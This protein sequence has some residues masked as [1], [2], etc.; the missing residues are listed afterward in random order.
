MSTDT[1]NERPRRR[2]ISFFS[3]FIFIWLSFVSVVVAAGV[4]RLDVM[5]GKMKDGATDA[6]LKE[7]AGRITDVARLN[8]E[9]IEALTNAPAP[10]TEARLVEVK[11]EI[12]QRVEAASTTSAERMDTIAA[13]LKAMEARL[14]TLEAN[15]EKL[16]QRAAATVATPAT[17]ATAS[18]AAPL[19][20][21]FRILGVESRGGERLLSIAPLAASSIDDISLMRVGASVERWRLLGFDASSALFAIGDELKRIPLP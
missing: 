7:L 12:E 14:N 9:R 13:D 4:L 10:A 18:R 3:I 5:N 11:D 6:R 2:R 8:D 16:K 21:P 15:F 1:L 19:S 17:A 20:P